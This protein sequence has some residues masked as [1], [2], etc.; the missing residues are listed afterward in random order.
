MKKILV[1]NPG[2]TSTKIALYEGGNRLWQQDV[3]HEA[4]RIKAFGTIYA[5]LDFRLDAVS[6]ALKAHGTALEELACVGARGG[7]LPPLDSGTYAVDEHMLDV[8]ENRPVNHHASN[9]GA[10]LAYRIAKPL[11]FPPIS[12]TP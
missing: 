10:A 11:A 9:L 12:A 1:I 6:D 3:E 7:L 2:S 4:G 5:Q 8:L